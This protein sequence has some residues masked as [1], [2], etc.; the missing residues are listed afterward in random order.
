MS[1]AVSTSLSRS[2]RPLDGTLFC[3]PVD[4]HKSGDVL[5]GHVPTRGVVAEPPPTDVRHGRL[6]HVDPAGQEDVTFER[7]AGH[8]IP[9]VSALDRPDPIDRERAVNSLELEIDLRGF[10]WE[11]FCER[12][13]EDREDASALLTARNLLDRLTLVRLRL[14][15]DIDPAGSASHVDGPRPPEP[16][17]ERH[18]VELRGATSPVSEVPLDQ[19]FADS[20]R[21]TR[22]E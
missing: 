22:V 2:G 3:V 16:P 10:R 7:V 1:P 12:R 6:L 11:R 18:A 14:R 20:A 5:V 4:G 21:L 19:R 17:R 9:N 15:V 13:R 8:V